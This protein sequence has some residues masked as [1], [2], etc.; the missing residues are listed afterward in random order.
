MAPFCWASPPL[1][2]VRLMPSETSNTWRMMIMPIRPM[3]MATISS[4]MLKPRADFEGVRMGLRGRVVGDGGERRMLVRGEVFGD[5]LGHP[6]AQGDL[7]QAP[8]RSTPGHGD[9]RRVARGIGQ[10]G[11]D[12]V[13]PSLDLDGR[14][15]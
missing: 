7:Y 14:G 6:P 4:I 10:P 11:V 2:V 5:L 9:D 12:P 3:T 13:H 1:V 8:E 15:S